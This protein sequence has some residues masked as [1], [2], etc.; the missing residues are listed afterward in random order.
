MALEGGYNLESL[1]E[2]AEAVIRILFG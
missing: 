2:C 1:Q